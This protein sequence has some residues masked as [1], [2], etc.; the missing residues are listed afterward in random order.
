MV[1]RRMEYLSGLY[2]NAASRCGSTR[3][4]DRW[5]LTCEW[6]EGKG[7]GRGVLASARHANQ[8]GKKSEQSRGQCVTG[9]FLA[10][11]REEGNRG[12][13]TSCQ[14]PDCRLLDCGT[15]GTSELDWRNRDKMTRGRQ[16]FLG[17]AADHESMIIM[18]FIR[19]TAR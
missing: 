8:E 16:T 18:S 5:A 7:E 2:C 17:G 6:T 1:Q 4:D 11:G 3:P 15:G 12:T 10:G 9:D 13:T 14:L 19:Q